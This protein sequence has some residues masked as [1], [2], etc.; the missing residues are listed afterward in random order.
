MVAGM[1]R[2]RTEAEQ[3]QLAETTHTIE[4]FLRNNPEHPRLFWLKFQSLLV[5]LAAA[6]RAVLIA[7][8]KS[9]DDPDR[10][11]ALT[12]IVRIAGAMRELSKSIEDQVAIERTKG[13][14]SVAVQDLVSLAVVVA[15][16][17]IDAVMV[18]GDLFDEAYQEIKHLGKSNYFILKN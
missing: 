16:K 8:V 4:V 7:I 1:L 5:E 3:A 2:D 12:R 13:S 18:R 17:R 9:P 6:K 15:T 11:K 14:D 10:D